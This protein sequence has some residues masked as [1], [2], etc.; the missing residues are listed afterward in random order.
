MK[1]KVNAKGL[2][3]SNGAIPVG[4]VITVKE[5]PVSWKHFGTVVETDEIED[6]TALTNPDNGAT[7]EAA[8]AAK[9]AADEKAAAEAAKK[10]AEDKGAK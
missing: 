8:D 3:G 6:K 9:K 2:Y 5:V 4:T 1:F 7:K 10:A